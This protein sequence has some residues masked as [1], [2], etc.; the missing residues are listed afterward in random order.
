MKSFEVAVR[1]PLAVLFLAVISTTIGCALVASPLEH[2]HKTINVPHVTCK[3]LD[4]QTNNGSIVV[5]RSDRPDV[6][7]AGDI[8]ATTPERVAAAKIVATRN[9][10][11]TL[12]VRCDWPDGQ[13][14]DGEGCSFVVNIPDATG[15]TLHTDNGSLQAVDFAGPAKMQTTN[16]NITLDRQAGDIDANTQNGQIKISEA[17]GAVKAGTANGEIGIALSAASTG[18]VEAS[19]VNASV[20]LV[21]GHAFTGQLSLSTLN[22]SVQVDSSVKARSESAGMNELQLSFADGGAKS[23]AST[24]NGAVY[25]RMLDSA[26]ASAH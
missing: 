26:A 25:V 14:L 19:G 1:D 20:N 5:T 12:V 8:A 4:V 11:G 3:P 15:V 21:I 23:S 10:D 9:A 18:P 22:G 7:I 17:A 24:V 2:G 13:P 6:E 16:G